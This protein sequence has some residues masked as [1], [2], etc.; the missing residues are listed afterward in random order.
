MRRATMLA[1]VVCVLLVGSAGVA[2]AEADIFCTGGRCEG[3][4]QLDTIFG[5]V[6]SDQIFALGGRDFVAA[7][8][9]QDELNGQNGSDALYGE[10]NADTY[11]GGGGSDEL[12]EVAVVSEVTN[13]GADVMNGGTSDDYMEG[14]TGADILR[15]QA[16]DE[17]DGPNSF[18]HMFGD[19]GNDDLF[20]GPGEDCIEG[21]QGTDEHFGGADNDLILA[22]NGDQVGTADVVDCGGGEDLALVR[23]SEDIVSDNCER[24]HEGQSTASVAPSDGT[25]DEDQQ[26]IKEAFRA[27]HGL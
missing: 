26:Q 4:E 13:S 21:E 7:L 3:T 14:N 17:C 1:V 22:T 8:A 11:N 9:G 12:S 18:A 27:E 23:L 19:Q 25:T 10:N 20:G 15:G 5:T 2:L 24:V 6:Q 16:G